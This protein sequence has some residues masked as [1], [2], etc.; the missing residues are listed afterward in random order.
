MNE[1]NA[2]LS[3]KD[4]EITVLKSKVTLLQDHV[5]YSEASSWEKTGWTVWKKDSEKKSDEV[6]G[7]VINI[8]KE[9]ETKNPESALDRAH[10]IGP[11]YTENDAGKKM[12]SIIV[13]FM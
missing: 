11:R 1:V 2:I 7:K 9:S 5:E 3:K 13:R 6:L 12:R 10:C 8:I 4:Q